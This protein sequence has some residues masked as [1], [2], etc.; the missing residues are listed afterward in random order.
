VLVVLPSTRPD[1]LAAARAWALT[2]SQARLGLSSSRPE[3]LAPLGTV[4]SKYSVTTRALRRARASGGDND[5][6]GGGSGLRFGQAGER[7]NQMVFRGIL[8]GGPAP[9]AAAAATTGAASAL[10]NRWAKLSE[11]SSAASAAT[12]VTAFRNPVD[13]Q[14]ADAVVGR[15]AMHEVLRALPSLR[16]DDLC[17]VLH[18][19]YR[20]PEQAA[21]LQR[22]LDQGRAVQAGGRAVKVGDATL[23]ELRLAATL[24]GYTADVPGNDDPERDAELAAGR[25]ELERMLHSKS[26]EEEEEEGGGGG[27][28]TTEEAVEVQG[29]GEEKV[30]GDGGGNASAEEEGGAGDGGGAVSEEAAEGGD[31]GDGAVSAQVAA[32]DGSDDADPELPPE[33]HRDRLIRVVLTMYGQALVHDAAKAGRLLANSTVLDTLGAADA[34]AA[35][36]A[37][38]AAGVYGRFVLDCLEPADA[39]P[40]DALATVTARACS[41]DLLRCSLF[42]LSSWQTKATAGGH[43]DEDPTRARSKLWSHQFASS[44]RAAASARYAA[45]DGLCVVGVAWSYREAFMSDM[46]AAVQ[47][48]AQARLTSTEALGVVNGVLQKASVSAVLFSRYSLVLVGALY[49]PTAL[50]RALVRRLATSGAQLSLPSRIAV[51]IQEL[52]RLVKPP[53]EVS[54]A[55]PASLSLLAPVVRVAAG[56]LGSSAEALSAAVPAMRAY[57]EALTSTSRG[58]GWLFSAL[59]GGLEMATAATYEMQEPEEYERCFEGGGGGEEGGGGAA[60]EE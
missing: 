48:D 2:E 5:D 15:H 19:L 44:E 32:A 51:P 28:A 24:V 16:I 43:G 47:R 31:G 50:P 20:L 54:L 49:P 11:L 38:T 14:R 17:D 26:A 27:G 36:A 59:Q 35:R 7:F 42:G 46:E 22:L 10:P 57:A 30:G 52:Q 34:T 40:L 6:E 41:N 23:S 33:Q 4:A 39:M 18:H 45:I 25:A 1:K 8:S 12:D 13:Y 53:L 60:M 55:S 56:V 37:I 9:A 58:P 29:E 21:H 3:M